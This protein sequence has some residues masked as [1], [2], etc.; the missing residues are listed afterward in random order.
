MLK[1]ILTWLLGL[2]F[3]V[4]AAHAESPLAKISALASG[5]LLLNGR[6]VDLA[7]IEAEF[8]RLQAE[9]GVVW[10]YREN[11]RSEPSPAAIEVIQLIIQYRL[12]IS[13]SSKSDFS[14]Y[15]DEN[16]RSQPRTL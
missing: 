16:R 14:D 4:S 11:P 10:Y 8:K 5:A 12:P 9:D 1:T 6:A 2:V 7:S 13:F 3:L 15:I